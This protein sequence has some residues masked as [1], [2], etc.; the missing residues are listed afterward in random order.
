MPQLVRLQLVVAAVFQEQH[1]E[2]LPS[3][4]DRRA[5]RR[6]EDAQRAER[7]DA[8]DAFVL[9]RRMPRGDVADL[10]AEHAGQLRFVVEKRQDAARDVDE[11]ARQRERVD[12][13]LIDDGELPGQVRPLGELREL[14]ADVADVLVSSGSL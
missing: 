6:N 4:S 10:V 12:C 2:R 11:A 14:E 5:A 8:A 7:G 1:A 3:R 13:R 9:P